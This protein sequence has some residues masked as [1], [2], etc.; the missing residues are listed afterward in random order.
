MRQYRAVVKKEGLWGQPNLVVNPDAASYK[1]SLQGQ[2]Y[3]VSALKSVA[4]SLG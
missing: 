3:K 2:I 1:L 4:Q